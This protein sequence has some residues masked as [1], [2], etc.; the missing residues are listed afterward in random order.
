MTRFASRK[1]ALTSNGIGVQ[2]IPLPAGLG[3]FT[4]GRGCLHIKVVADIDIYVLQ[5]LIVRALKRESTD[6]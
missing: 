3:K 6:C 5:V 2:D 4:T 1:Q